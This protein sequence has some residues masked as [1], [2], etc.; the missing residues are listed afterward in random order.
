MGRVGTGEF[1]WE[2]VGSTQLMPVA[3]EKVIWSEPGIKNSVEASV[4]NNPGR[5]K[6]IT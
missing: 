3:E 1:T 4:V 5:Q 2:I 6:I